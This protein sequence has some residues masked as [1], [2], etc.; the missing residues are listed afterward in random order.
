MLLV[1]VPHFTYFKLSLDLLFWVFVFCVIW[2]GGDRPNKV[3]LFYQRERQHARRKDREQL[4]REVV[5]AVIGAVFGSL[6]TL[7][8]EALLKHFQH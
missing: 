4:S 3:Y 2:Y 6:L 8:G 1:Y 7:I 5:A